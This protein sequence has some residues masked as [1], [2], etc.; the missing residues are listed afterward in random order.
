MR[1]ILLLGLCLAATGCERYA[2][3]PFVGFG[4]F[5]SDTHNVVRNPN[6]PVGNSE[7]IQRVTGLNLESEPLLPES[8]NVWPGPA[9]PD[10]TLNDLMRDNP[11]GQMMPGTEMM[12]PRG[13]STPPMNVPP[14]S[15]GSPNF[16]PPSANT[17]QAP[18]PSRFLQTPQGPA[19]ISGPPGAQTYTPPTGLPGLVVPNGNGTSTLVAPDGTV[20]TVPTPK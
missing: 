4:G 5:V 16:G 3:N 11:N 18:P 17:P 1:R 15:P 6:R 2:G 13:S 19:A 9:K 12:M 14:P 8:G 20:Q 10:P 7:N